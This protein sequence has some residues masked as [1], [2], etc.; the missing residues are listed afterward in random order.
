MREQASQYFQNAYRFLR[1]LNRIP[2]IPGTRPRIV[3]I[4]Y[5]NDSVNTRQQPDDLVSRLERAVERVRY[6]FSAMTI[7]E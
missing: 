3:V 2:E 7:A 5:S 1:R 6:R 4:P